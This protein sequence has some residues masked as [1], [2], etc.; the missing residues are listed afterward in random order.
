MQVNNSRLNNGVNEITQNLGNVSPGRDTHSQQVGP[1]RYPVTALKNKTEIKVATWNV[2]TL[3]R[4]GKLGN[5]KK[6]TV[7]CNVNIMGV[8]EVRRK[9]AGKITTDKH[10]F[11]YTGGE[12][13]ERGVCMLID[14]ATAKS[15][16]RYWAISDRV[17]LVKF[18]GKPFDISVIHSRDSFTES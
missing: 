3:F 8:S 5:L 6:E 1:D 11:V 12:V 14:Q 16:M 9:G 18:R 7:R 15:M 17:I 2:C 10:T 4:S 13:L